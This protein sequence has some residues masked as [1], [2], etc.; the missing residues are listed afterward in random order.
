MIPASSSTRTQSLSSGISTR[1]TTN[2]GVS[3]Q[4]IGVFPSATPNARA[5]TATGAAV[6]SARTISTSGISGAGIE[7]VHPDRAFRQL[8]HRRDLGHGQRRRVRRE[9]RLVGDDVLE[10]PEELVLDGELFERSLDHELAAGELRQ[11]GRQTKP[12]ERR[13]AR[14]GVQLPLV[15]LAREEVSDPYARGLAGIGVQLVPDRREACLDR[16]LGDARAHR[17]E[18]DDPDRPNAAR[19]HNSS[20]T[21]AIAIPNPTHIDA[22]P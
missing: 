2:P 12:V 5:A 9:D 6:R 8:Q 17:P 7:E 10:R 1:L 16:E 19:R 14:V 18:A 4:S 3:E 20:T 13:V 21:P 15:D 22:I 11:V